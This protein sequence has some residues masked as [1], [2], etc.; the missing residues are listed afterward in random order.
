[1]FTFAVM[2]V[3]VHYS[4][5]NGQADPDETWQTHSSWSRKCFSQVKVEVKFGERRRHENGGAVDADSFR[6]EDVY[7]G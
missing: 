2:G 6:R 3:Y 1:L 4:R 7:Y 5:L